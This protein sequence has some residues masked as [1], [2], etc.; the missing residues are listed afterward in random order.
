VFSRASKLVAR[1]VIMGI[2]FERVLLAALV[3]AAV[4]ATPVAAQQIDPERIFDVTLEVNGQM[5]TA[6]IREGSFLRLTLRETDEYHLSPVLQQG[7]SGRVLLAVSLGTVGQPQSRRIV[8]RLELSP[9]TPAA[10]RSAPTLRI[11]VD[12]IRRADPRQSAAGPSAGRSGAFRFASTAQDGSC[13]VC[14]EGACACACGV[15]MSC[16]HCCTTGCCDP[17]FPTSNDRTPILTG[18]ARFAALTG[19]TCARGSLLDRGRTGPAR[20]VRTALR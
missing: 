8:E 13:C 12:A 19:N 20:E 1:Q 17:M 11:V 7:R 18:P 16:G 14:C 15:R 2:R 4:A 9:G 3:L 6:V 5:M 10:L